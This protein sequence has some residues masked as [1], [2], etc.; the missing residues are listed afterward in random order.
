LKDEEEEGGEKQRI[1]YKK[2]REKTDNSETRM[3]INQ[4]NYDPGRGG[5]GGN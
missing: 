4:A 2:T 3:D 1:G 5:K